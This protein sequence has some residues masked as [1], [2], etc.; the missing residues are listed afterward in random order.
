MESVKAF[1][2]PIFIKATNF[3][4]DSLEVRVPPFDTLLLHHNNFHHSLN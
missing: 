1:R 2:Y 3:F 4:V